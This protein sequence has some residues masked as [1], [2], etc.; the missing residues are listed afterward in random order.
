MKV[1]KFAEAA[2]AAFTPQGGT[3]GKRAHSQRAQERLIYYV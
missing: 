3:E 2:L 1:N